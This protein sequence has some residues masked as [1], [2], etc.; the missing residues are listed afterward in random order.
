MK[1][2]RLIIVLLLLRFAMPLGAGL[3]AQRGGVSE[4]DLAAQREATS[5]EEIERGREAFTGRWPAPSYNWYDS[6]QD[7]VQP[8]D[9]ET[10]FD[11]SF[12]SPD[13]PSGSVLKYVA[14]AAL[15][16]LLGILAYLLIK[17]YLNREDI[18]LASSTA[19]GEA[20]PLTAA[21]IEAL[22]FPARR[23]A[24]DLL[25]MARDLYLN[26]QYSQAI[27]YLFS[28]ELVLLDRAQHIALARGKT[29]RTYLRE[30]AHHPLL[31][32]MLARTTSAFESAFF[33]RHVLD[34]RTF[35]TCWQELS[36]LT[37][38]AEQRA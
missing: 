10:P 1:P 38:L 18:G 35:E 21:Q 23:Q 32:Q 33:G 15:A 36:E 9:V 24:D 29:N 5:A 6:Q 7:E 4:Q 31:K 19:A 25:G 26:G 11:W 2:F 13:L 3:P 8:I 34:R 16:L 14:W 28:H 17:A 30:L 20:Q 27:V 37:R 22:P 12:D